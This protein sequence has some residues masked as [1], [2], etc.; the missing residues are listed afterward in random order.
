MDMSACE[1]NENSVGI[2]RR[3]RRWMI[4]AVSIGFFRFEL[5]LAQFR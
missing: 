3:L 5:V 4:G 1:K 2:A